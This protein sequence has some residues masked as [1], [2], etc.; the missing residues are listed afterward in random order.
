MLYLK[1]SRG[2]ERGEYAI[3]RQSHPTAVEDLPVPPVE[4]TEYGEQPSFH[5]ETGR[6]DVEAMLEALT[7]CGFRWR[8]CR[9]VLEFGCSN[10]R[11]L[12]WLTPYADGR[13]VWGVD[14]QSDQ[15]LWAAENLSPPLN[16]STTTTVPHLP[17][18]DRHFDLVYA[19]SIFTH[20]GEL[21]VAWLLELARVLSRRGYL[22]LTMHDESF[23]RVVLD[24]QTPRFVP[25]ANLIRESSHIE[26]LERGD[27]DFVSTAPYGDAGL[28]QVMMSAEYIEHV[29]RPFLR[30]VG[31]A[32]RA[33]ADA[34][35]AYVF[36]LAEHRGGRQRQ[37]KSE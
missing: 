2:D 27:F 13:E 9:S 4:L 32:E 33:Y 10:G 3:R 36:T 7:G 1:T 21:H 12:R 24:D 19:G 28:S 16:F 30:L 5:L 11:M 18:P 8:G 15:V 34:Q 26:E 20:L 23:V 6:T 14:I 37:E 35:T 22:Y 25:I 17:F 31:R 29:T